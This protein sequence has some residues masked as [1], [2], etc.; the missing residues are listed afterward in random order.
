MVYAPRDRAGSW[1]LRDFALC[2]DEGQDLRALNRLAGAGRQRAR[3]GPALPVGG[4]TA[5]PF[6]SL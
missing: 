5:A 3:Q 4:R 2:A 6:S 1:T